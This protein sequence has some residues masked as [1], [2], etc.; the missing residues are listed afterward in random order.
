MLKAIQTLF[1][2][3]TVFAVGMVQA[4][5]V[6]AGYW[7]GCTGERAG[8]ADCVEAACHPHQAHADGCEDSCG[9]IHGESCGSHDQGS[10]QPAP[11]E[12]DHQHTELRDSFVVTTFPPGLA[13]PP[14]L[15]AVLPTTWEVPGWVPTVTKPED[16]SPPPRPPEDT[17]PPM[18]L[19]VAETTVLLV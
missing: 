13:M 4:V 3:L 6:Q 12:H 7:C 10:G 9:H 15:C 1:V 5:G 19:L 8:S 16:V 18:C 14:M 17:G 2:I 11:V